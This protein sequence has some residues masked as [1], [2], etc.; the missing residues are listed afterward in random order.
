MIIGN[1]TSYTKSEFYQIVDVSNKCLGQSLSVKCD[2][3]N[4]LNNERYKQFK[5]NYQKRN[6]SFVQISFLVYS[7]IL[8][9]LI[10]CR[11]LQKDF[12]SSIFKRHLQEKKPFSW[13]IFNAFRASTPPCWNLSNSGKESI[14]NFSSNNLFTWS[15]VNVNIK[16]AKSLML[17]TVVF[18]TVYKRFFV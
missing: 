1:C 3:W 12:F 10:L 7:F 4:G 18:H 9:W 8:S 17:N 6:N 15:D 16:H 14:G 11:F 5:S 13:T 2:F